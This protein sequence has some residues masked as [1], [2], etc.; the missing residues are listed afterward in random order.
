MPAEA[1]GAVHITPA[2]KAAAAAPTVAINT[3]VFMLGFRFSGRRRHSAAA[4]YSGDSIC[5]TALAR[6]AISSTGH[7]DEP[8]EA[9]DDTLAGMTR[10]LLGLSMQY[11]FAVLSTEMPAVDAAHV[12]AAASRSDCPNRA[13][14]LPPGWL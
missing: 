6:A 10:V 3:L 7:A 8:W 1:D 4:G 13:R 9:K 5:S 2:A 11:A 14:D 12:L